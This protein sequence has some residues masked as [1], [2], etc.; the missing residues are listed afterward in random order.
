V[1]ER[2]LEETPGGYYILAGDNDGIGTQVHIWGWAPNFGHGY[3]YYLVTYA[4]STPEAPV[5]QRFVHL[6]LVLSPN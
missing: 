1:T 3:E 2:A 5:R 6:P 4:L